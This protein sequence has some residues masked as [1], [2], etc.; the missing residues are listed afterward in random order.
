M[1]KY[2]I[3]GERCS[4]TNF[5]EY[6]LNLNFE[7][8]IGH[9]LIHKHFFTYP[10]FLDIVNNN[11]SYIYLLIVRNPIDYLMSF[12]NLPHHQPKERLVDL[13]TF[14]LSEFYSVNLDGSE[15]VND[16]NSNNR[17]YKNIFDMRSDKCKFL[18]D[19]M[20][21]ITNNFHFIRYEDFKHNTIG[22]LDILKN[23]FELVKKQDEYILEKQYVFCGKVL[24]RRIM[25]N[26]EIDS[27]TKKIIS[28]NLDFN[29]E[30]KMGYHPESRLI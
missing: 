13:S 5:L 27:D 21:T 1:K 3:L 6:H 18:F 24:D 30:H 14:L 15:I 17:R 7:V 10:G 11:R 9:V 12:W 23:K 25:E 8:S 4:G 29:I 19:I 16:R 2:V 28:E 22:I 26:Y 20:P